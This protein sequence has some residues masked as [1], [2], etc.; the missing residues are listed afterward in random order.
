MHIARPV[1]YIGL[2]YNATLRPNHLKVAFDT[3]R[4]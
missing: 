2:E 3:T 1:E 4:T